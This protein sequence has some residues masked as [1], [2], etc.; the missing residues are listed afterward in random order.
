M[1]SGVLGEPC[2]SAS[3]GG[4]SLGGEESLPQN[5]LS[6]LPSRRTADKGLAALS[7][8]GRSPLSLKQMAYGECVPSWHPAGVCGA[9]LWLPL[10]DRRGLSWP[11]AD[12]LGQPGAESERERELLA[13]R[14]P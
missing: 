11:G 7:E 3:L 4:R 1:A 10:L 8:G 9:A 13:L 14:V 5:A 2:G 12:P 6:R